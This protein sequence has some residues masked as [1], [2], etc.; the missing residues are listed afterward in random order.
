[1]RLLS[2]VYYEVDFILMA[3]FTAFDCGVSKE[4]QV[5]NEMKKITVRMDDEIY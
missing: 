5:T 4:R 1:M 3:L 2:R